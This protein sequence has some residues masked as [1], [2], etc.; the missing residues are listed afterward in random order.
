MTDRPRFGQKE[1]A[2]I[3]PIVMEDLVDATEGI[4]PISQRPNAIYTHRHFVYGVANAAHQDKSIGKVANT[5]RSK[6]KDVHSFLLT[7]GFV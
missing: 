4:V 2:V 6:F 1:L 3:Q 5:T 7:N